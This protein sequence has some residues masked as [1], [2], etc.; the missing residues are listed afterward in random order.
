MLACALVV[1]CTRDPAPQPRPEPA[2]GQVIEI[3]PGDL[4]PPSIDQEIRFTIQEP[5]ALLG[6]TTSSDVDVVEAPTRNYRAAL[7][8]LHE[9]APGQMSVAVPADIPALAAHDPALLEVSSAARSQDGTTWLLDNP[10][11][12][13]TGVPRLTQIPAGG[14]ARVHS[15]LAGLQLSRDRVRLTTLP[16]GRVGYIA[17]GRVHALA[18]DNGPA[19]A[20]DRVERISA[21]GNGG[22]LAAV[23]QGSERTIQIVRVSP[24]GSAR[25]FPLPVRVREDPLR[26]GDDSPMPTFTGAVVALTYDG[27]GGAFVAIAERTVDDALGVDI[28]TSSMLLHLL[29]DGTTTMLMRGDKQGRAHCATLRQPARASDAEHDMGRITDLMVRGDQLWITDSACRRVLALRLGTG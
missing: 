26:S 3:L 29:S 20:L 25:T 24:G 17:R 23:R 5:I 9:G 7:W 12:I 19:P 1:G 21:T 8:R 15:M 13:R 11:H 14:A 18:G 4:R 28:D 2:P 6:A 10:A 27:H 22:Y 16:D